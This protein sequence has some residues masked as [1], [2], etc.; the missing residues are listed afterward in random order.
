MGADIP[1]LN[2]SFLVDHQS[3]RAFIEHGSGAKF[4]DETLKFLQVQIETT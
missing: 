2:F 4:H 1:R 3:I